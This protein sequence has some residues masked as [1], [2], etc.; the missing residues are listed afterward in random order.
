MVDLIAD[1]GTVQVAV[2]ADPGVA[3]GTV[4]LRVG[5]ADVDAGRLIDASAPVTGVRVG[6]R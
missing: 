5:Q 4:H 3:R 2:T 1:R 6:R